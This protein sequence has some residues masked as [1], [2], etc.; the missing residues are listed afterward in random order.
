MK[1]SWWN[2]FLCWF[3]SYVIQFLSDVYTFGNDFIWFCL[4][5]Y[6]C[7]MFLCVFKCFFICEV[8][9]D[10]IWYYVLFTVCPIFQYFSS[11][12]PE[13]RSLA[14][15]VS[16]WTFFPSTNHLTSMSMLLGTMTSVRTALQWKMISDWRL[17]VDCVRTASVILTVT[18]IFL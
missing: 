9:Y 15:K 6:F 11:R 5:V 17:L 2:F 16:E 8:L 14:L 1:L 7:M 18:E 3:K 12:T 13:T 4:N 10:R